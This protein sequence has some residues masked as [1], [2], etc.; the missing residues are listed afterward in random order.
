LISNTPTLVTQADKPVTITNVVPTDVN[1][2]GLL[3]VIISFKVS[4]D[5]STYV[6]QCIGNAQQFGV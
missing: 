6:W 2:D 4:G 5:T 3:D 1:Y